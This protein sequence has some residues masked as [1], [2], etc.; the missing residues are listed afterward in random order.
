MHR[1]LV[2]CQN[3]NSLLCDF[4]ALERYYKPKTRV[5]YREQYNPRTQNEQK[6]YRYCCK[7]SF[8]QSGVYIKDVIFNAPATIV[9]WS[10]GTKTVVKSGDYDVYDPEKGLSMAIAKKA[11]GNEGNYY[12]VFKKWLSK[13]DISNTNLEQLKEKINELGKKLYEGFNNGIKK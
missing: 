3:A 5:S 6:K 10:D 13:E 4:C 8:S 9:F 1:C 7:N 11:L 12:E 2:T